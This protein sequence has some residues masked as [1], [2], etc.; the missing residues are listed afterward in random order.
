MMES[1]L[2]PPLWMPLALIV[3]GVVLLFVLRTMRRGPLA[4]AVVA[5]LG[6]AWFGLDLLTETPREEAYRRTSTIIHSTAEA[7][8]AAFGEAMDEQTGLPGFY[9]DKTSFVSG[10]QATVQRIGLKSVTIT[11][12]ELS[13][14]AGLILVDATVWSTQD[15]TD[16][17]PQ[18]SRWRFRYVRTD[19]GLVLDQIEPLELMGSDVS[20]INDYLSRH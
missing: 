4:A 9:N 14:E 19:G 2:S 13:E 10:A 8:W 5:L 1:L 3:A 11:S 17:R 7:D 15:V 18:K 16:D 6:V 20:R 12:R